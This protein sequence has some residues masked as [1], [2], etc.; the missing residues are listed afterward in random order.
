MVADIDEHDGGDDHIERAPSRPR[1]DDE[2]ALRIRCEPE[3][4]LNDKRLEGTTTDPCK[5]FGGR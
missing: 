3:V 4:V 2:N 5:R 1:N